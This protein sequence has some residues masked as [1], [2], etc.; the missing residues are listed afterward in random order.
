MV[1]FFVIIY[2]NNAEG[3]YLHL[4]TITIINDAHIAVTIQSTETCI[5]NGNWYLIFHSAN[6]TN[7]TNITMCLCK[8]QITSLDDVS[9]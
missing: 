2:E 4:P 3:I 5:L 8:Y 7:L 9:K 6:L 1:C